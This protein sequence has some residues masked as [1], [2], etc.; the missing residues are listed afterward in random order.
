MGPRHR[1]LPSPAMIVA[2][3]ALITALGG[4]AA[5]LSGKDTVAHNDLFYLDN[6]D[7]LFSDAKQAAGDIASE[8]GNL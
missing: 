8:I 4:T 6:T 1:L 5:A 3:I 7:M 2:G